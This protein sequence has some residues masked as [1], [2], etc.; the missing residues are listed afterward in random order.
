M[1]FKDLVREG[2]QSIFE[3]VADGE[4]LGGVDPSAL[5]AEATIRRA[6]RRSAGNPA[7][8][9]NKRA[10]LAEAGAKAL[11]KRLALAAKRVARIHSRRKKAQASR[12]RDQDAAFRRMEEEA[13][14]SPPPRSSTRRSASGSSRRTRS[15]SKR[16]SAIAQSYKTLEVEFGSDLATTKTSYRKLLRKFHPDLHQDPKKKKAATELTIKIT[17]AYNAIEEHLK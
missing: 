3:K 5:E 10:R 16:S 12:K 15:T 6:A 11:E 14:Q 9:D 2:M 17:T 7:P 1:S 4:S 8:R 13:R